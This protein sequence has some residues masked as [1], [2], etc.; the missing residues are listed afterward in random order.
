VGGEEKGEKCLE[1]NRL[2]QSLELPSE[3]SVLDT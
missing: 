3:G 2:L 1:R